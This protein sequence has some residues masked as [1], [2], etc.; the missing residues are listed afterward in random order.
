MSYLLLNEE[1]ARRTN[2]IPNPDGKIEEHVSVKEFREFLCNRI[3]DNREIIES[4]LDR[5]L[6]KKLFMPLIYGKTLIG[7]ESDIRLKYGSQISRSDSF[8]LA[9]LFIEFWNKKYPDI[10]NFMKLINIISSLCSIK[11]RA[12]VYKVPYFTTK[13]NS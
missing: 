12:I 2:L 3:E 4:Q 6:I 8:Y 10:V 5:K 7:I 11:D 13:Q 9:K 1:M